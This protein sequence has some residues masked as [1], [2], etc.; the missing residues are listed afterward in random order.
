MSEQRLDYREDPAING[1]LLSGSADCLGAVLIG[2]GKYH[3]MRVNDGDIPDLVQ[4]MLT[5]EDGSGQFP[6][7]L[8]QRT[9]MGSYVARVDSDDSGRLVLSLIGDSFEKPE[10]EKIKAAVQAVLKS[11]SGE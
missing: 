9:L 7:D 11:L 4:A 3:H 2:L 8:H 10:F 6:D 1:V 5:Y